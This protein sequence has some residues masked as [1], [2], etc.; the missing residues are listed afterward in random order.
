MARL[1]IPFVCTAFVVGTMLSYVFT[2]DLV[3]TIPLSTS[4]LSIGVAYII[5]AIFGKPC[6]LF[7]KDEKLTVS[8]ED[9]AFHK[10][11][12]SRI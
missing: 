10:L 1:Y 7:G 6:E 8:E 9:L 11:L 3:V 12:I 5:G 2:G 4:L